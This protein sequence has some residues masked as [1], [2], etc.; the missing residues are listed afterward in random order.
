MSIDAEAIADR[1][2]LRRKL[3]F[4]RVLG[5]LALIAAVVALGAMLPPTVPVGVRAGPYRA[6]LGRRLHRRQP[7]HRPI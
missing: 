4:W 6:D 7:A 3:S 5:V 1:R 2:R